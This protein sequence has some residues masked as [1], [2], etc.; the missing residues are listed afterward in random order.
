ME[1]SGEFRNRL[2]GGFVVICIAMIAVSG[3]FLAQTY[4]NLSPIGAALAGIML[5]LMLFLLHIQ[6]INRREINEFKYYMG[7]PSDIEDGLVRRIDELSRQVNSSDVS[8]IEQSMDSVLQENENTTAL[9]AGLDDGLQSLSRRVDV[10]ADRMAISENSNAG[11]DGN[12]SEFT[13]QERKVVPLHNSIQSPISQPELG[14]RQ[15]L[16]GDVDLIN[17]D[18]KRAATL[19]DIGAA[20]L[21]EHS[22]NRSL[23]ERLRNAVEANELEL[24]L[25]PIVNLNDRE[26]EYYESTLRLKEPDGGYV[27]QRKLNRFAR[28]GQLAVSLD[29]QLLF[30]AVRVLRTLNELQKRTGLFCPLSASTLENPD[31]FDD[32]HTFLAAN[33][34][35]AGS[36]ILE[37]NQSTLEDLNSD[38]RDRLSRL[39][40]LGFPLLLNNI[41][42]FELDGA[43]LHSAG[44]RNLKVSVNELLKI[45]DNGNIDEHVTDF[46]EEMENCG[47]TVIVSDIELESQAIHLIDFDLPLG[48]GSLFSPSRPVKPELLKAT[49]E[50]D[51]VSGL[52]IA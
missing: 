47:L 32:M 27:D 16:T 30:S 13:E 52:N 12:F 24:H 41:Q 23:V 48:Q 28:E 2:I 10:I 34:A 38:S 26:P 21:S 3:A 4:L 46:S 29:S 20:D 42:N 8:S 37:I 43:L 1:N 15:D 31:A 6:R 40:D 44:F 39:V 19:A 14:H 18:D 36:L 25:Q 22:R 17:M 45:S 49:D 50:L 51:S 7:K 11:G 9:I 33:I 5:F 35:L